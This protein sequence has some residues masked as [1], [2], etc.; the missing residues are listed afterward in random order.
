M[1][2]TVSTIGYEGSNIEDF[3]A[4]LMIKNISVLIDIRDRPLSRKKGFLRTHWRMH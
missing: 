1:Q 2:N 3:V 4:T